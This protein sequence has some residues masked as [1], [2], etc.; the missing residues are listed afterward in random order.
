VIVSLFPVL[1]A[2]LDGMRSTDPGLVELFQVNRAT[3]LQ[4][5]WKLE[6]PWAIPSIVTGL[7]IAAGLAVIGA[8]PGRCTQ[9][10]A[11]DP[12]SS[13][14]GGR[15]QAAP[16]AKTAK[17]ASKATPTAAARPAGGACQAAAALAFPSCQ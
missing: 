2:T 6:L 14:P 17:P 11:S 7:R 15:A 8:V 9:T 16:P 10:S 4:R 5:W 13:S 3:R 1:A 12:P